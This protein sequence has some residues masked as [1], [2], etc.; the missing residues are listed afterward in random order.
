MIDAALARERSFSF[1]DVVTAGAPRRELP[2]TQSACTGSARD[3]VV[4]DRQG[5]GGAS[6]LVL[7]TSCV[8]RAPCSACA[9]EIGCSSQ[10]RRMEERCSVRKSLGQPSRVD[11]CTRSWSARRTG[12][13]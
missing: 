4:M 12:L 11:Q 9:T 2:K 1:A 7:L 10:Q 8:R 3:R 6:H 5:E 13:D